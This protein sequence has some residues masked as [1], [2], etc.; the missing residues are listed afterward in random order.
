[1]DSK[2]CVVAFDFDET[3]GHFTQPYRFWNHLKHFLKDQY[4]DDTYFFCFLDLFPGFFRTGLFKILNTV[5]KKNF[6]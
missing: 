2:I 3:I 5:K 4:I 1:M 6:G